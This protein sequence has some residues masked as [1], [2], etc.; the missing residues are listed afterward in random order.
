MKLKPLV[1][2]LTAALIPAL[3]SASSHREA[4]FISTMPTVDASDF[5]MFTSYAPGRSGYVTILANYNPLQDPGNGPIFAPLNQEAAYDINIDNNGD[6]R[7]DLVF[8]FRF[9]N[10]YKNL[11]VPAGTTKT[12]VPLLNIGPVSG[13][14]SPNLNR[15]EDY[16]ITVYNGD[17]DR[18]A[19]GQ[20]VKN[21]WGWTTFVKPV[22]NIG[23][24]SIANYEKYADQ[25]IYNVKVPGCSQEAHVF[26]GQR[27]D[28]FVVNIGEIFDLVNLNPAGPRD[29]GQNGLHAKNV[30]TI[31]MEIPKS[32]LLSK[33]KDPVIGGW[34]T[35]S[36]PS[37]RLL[38]ATPTGEE[39]AEKGV[40][41]LVQVS[42]LANPL[43]NEVIIGMPDKDRFNA[44]EPSNDQQFLHYVTNPS[45]P[46]ILH[47]LFGGAANIPHMPR[48]DLV[49]VFLTGVSGLN[50]PAHLTVPGEEMR[51][52]TSIAPTTPAKQNDLG[53]LGGDLA[54]FPNG[55]RPYDDVVDI[56]LRVAEG[57][58]CSK[59]IGSCGNETS[60]PNHGTP[61]T[62][63]ARSPGATAATEHVTGDEYASDTYLDY[64][65]YLEPPLPGSP[66][67]I[68]GLP[69]DGT[70]GPSNTPPP[71]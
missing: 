59:M 58:L 15:N 62:D 49:T 13:N 55:R 70:R 34:T 16:T 7:P 67:G 30:D 32:C 28:G 27:K 64:F 39:N 2:A 6:A 43:V 1:L 18:G 51:L 8:R 56:E 41:H 25:Y 19:R 46:V 37:T 20:A 35:A 26:V 31:A 12:P 53:V 9:T 60:D 4:P 24:K 66:N 14:N 11:A 10:N 29:G 71:H 61:Y 23:N 5:Y 17:P 69:P 22:D 36:L 65:P 57:A 47:T 42:R 48:N 3:A 21:S 50:Q 38:N 54:G 44:S 52:N 45:L 40:G 68:N 63:Q 33:T